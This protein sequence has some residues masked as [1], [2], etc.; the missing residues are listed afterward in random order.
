MTARSPLIL[1]VLSC[2]MVAAVGCAQN[3]LD[4]F[5]VANAHGDPFAQRAATPHEGEPRFVRGDGTLEPALKLLEDGYV[6]VGEANFWCSSSRVSNKSIRKKAKKLHAAVCLVWSQHRNTVHGNMPITVPTSTT[7]YNSGSFSGTRGYMGSYSGTSTTYGSRTTYLPY[8]IILMDYQ[9]SF[10]A[11]GTGS[12]LGC[13]TLELT[14]EQKRKLGRNTGLMI[15]CVQKRTP[16]S[17]AKILPG[18]IFCSSRR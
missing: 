6:F 15:A 2:V 18:D 5:Y 12:V 16:A 1:V 8:T 17:K 4:Q 11:K 9:I 3:P 14:T 7:T 10:W 13:V